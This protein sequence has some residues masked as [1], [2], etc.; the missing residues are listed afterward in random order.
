[1]YSAKIGQ[2]HSLAMADSMIFATAHIHHAIL[3]T[4]DADFRNLP[5]VKYFEKT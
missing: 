3:W 4:Q 1:M 2:E 5:G